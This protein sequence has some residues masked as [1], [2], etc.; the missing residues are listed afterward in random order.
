MSVRP[1]IRAL[2][3]NECVALLKR[4]HVG[5]LAF[6]L[7]DRVD[8]Q[9]LHYV[10]EGGWLYGRTSEGTKLTVLDRNRWVAF[11]VDE[12]RDPFDWDSVV[13]YGSFHRIEPD[14]VATVAR[15]AALMRT[16]VPQALMPDDPAPYRTVLFRISIGELIGRAARPSLASAGDG[17]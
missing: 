3:R 16:V 12:I 13:V 8:I 4:H 17:D 11:E 10:L 6:A 7:N 5:R 15:A 14:D 9:P 2:S 1:T